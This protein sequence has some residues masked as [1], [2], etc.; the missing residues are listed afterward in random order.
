MGLYTHCI[1]RTVD[2]HKSSAFYLTFEGHLQ[3]KNLR[4]T[5]LIGILSQCQGS[6]VPEAQHPENSPTPSVARGIHLCPLQSPDIIHQ[7]HAERM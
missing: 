5:P 7:R 1:H 4:S 3:I 2:R 6:L